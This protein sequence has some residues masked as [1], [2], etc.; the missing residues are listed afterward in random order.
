MGLTTTAVYIIMVVTVIPP[1]E[2]MGVPPLAAHM[3]ALFWGVLSNIIPPVAI[4]SFAAAGI[5][6]AGPM[7]TAVAG[8]RIGIP[9]LL[10]FATFVYNPALLLI[11]SFADII[12][13]CT[14]CIA[15][16]VYMSAA[17]Q[18][19]AFE[20]INSLLRAVLGAVSLIVLSPRWDLT[21]CGLAIGFVVM[22]SNYLASKKNAA[23]TEL[24][25]V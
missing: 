17:I 7:E 10:V 23:N 4:A 15:G 5:A 16:V 13:N 21:I 19:Y 24:M 1:I 14:G 6:K 20:K 3:Y 22:A 12:I 2:A 11:G 8:F 18:G 25:G 9:G